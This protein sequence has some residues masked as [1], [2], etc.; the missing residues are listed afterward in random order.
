MRPTI[1]LLLLVCSCNNHPGD[2]DQRCNPDGT[3]NGTM[4]RCE[5]RG[6]QAICYPIPV[7]RP[8]VHYRTD[9]EKFCDNCG[10]NCSD[11][12][13]R[14]CAYSDTSVWGAKPALCECK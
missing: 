14:T 9:A 11:A 2:V 3:C 12:G 6:V 10:Q 4:L 13:V 8:A 7:E 1:A 5:T